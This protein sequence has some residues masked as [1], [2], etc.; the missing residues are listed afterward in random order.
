[1]VKGDWEEGDKEA[2][3]KEK[4]EKG[5][6]VAWEGK[7]REKDVEKEGWEDEGGQAVEEKA[8]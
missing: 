4:E 2:L 8:G 7:E 1:M 3:A 5:E 6:R